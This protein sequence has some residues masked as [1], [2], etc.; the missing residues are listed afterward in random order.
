[1]QNIRR[2]LAGA[3]VAAAM[4]A[5]PSNA[6][7]ADTLQTAEN[8]RKLDIMLMVTSLRCRTGKDDFQPEY[9]KFSAAHLS[10]LNLAGRQLRTDLQ[11]RHGAKGAM[12]ALDRMSVGMANEY[13]QGHPWLEC[14]ELKKV[15]NNLS[16]ERDPNQLALAASQ[17]LDSRRGRNLAYLD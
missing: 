12:R 4:L 10:T 2:K 9:R 5:T 13:G 3:A 14:A 16:E 15:A 6:I 17:L 7:A 8:I 11:K 1:M